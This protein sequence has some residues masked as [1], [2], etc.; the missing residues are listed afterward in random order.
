M[1]KSTIEGKIAE[2]T[3]L[4]ELECLGKQY[5]KGGNYA[6]ALLAWM[7]AEEL[8]CTIYRKNIVA[9]LFKNDIQEHERQRVEAMVE[10][11][12]KDGDAD[13][14]ESLRVLKSVYI[15]SGTDAKDNT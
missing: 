2:L 14:Q 15:N 7:R 10:Q 1:R 12:L 11:W 9:L 3:D 6:T 5:A 4:D 8:G 13:V